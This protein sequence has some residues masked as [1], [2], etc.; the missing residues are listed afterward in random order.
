MINN[1]DKVELL[2]PAGDIESGY[3][4]IH[5]GADAVYLGLPKFSARFGA[6]NFKEEE[7]S[8]FVVY[9]HSRGKKVFLALNTL[10]CER[11]QSA[12]IDILFFAEEIGIDGI[13]VQDI[14]LGRLIKKHFPRLR[15]H[16]STQMAVHNRA[17]AEA[18]KEMGYNRVVLARELTLE[19]IRDISSI[20]GI[21]T[22]VFIHGALCIC[23]SGQCLFSSIVG[24]RSGNRGKCA[25]PCRLPYSLV[26]RDKNNNCS[27]IQNGYLLSTRDLCTLEELGS[28]ISS[29]VTSLKIEGRMKSPE[30]VATVTRIYRKYID[31]AKSKPNYQVNESDKIE[32]L[33]VFNRGSFSS[34]T[35]IRYSKS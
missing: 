19:E 30:Y 2:S 13:I 5:Y 29:N 6:T 3:A 14:G 12:I 8:S 31:I 11:E 27:T 21:E 32:L 9:A 25:Q 10:I 1:K 34:R 17:G 15:L 24:G 23:Y 4:A 16:G 33:Q 35:S 7:L 28:F 22:E 18:L 26:K 20:E